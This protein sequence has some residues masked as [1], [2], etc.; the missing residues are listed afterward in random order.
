MVGKRMEAPRSKIRVLDPVVANKI[1]AGEVVERP[2]SVV[3]ELVENSLDAG[4]TRLDI[5]VEEG[6]K[7]L[8]RVADNGCGMS[9]ED[10]I[11][12]LQRHATSK[13][14]TAEDL[15]HI[16]TLGFR[17]EALPSIAAVSQMTLTTREAESPAGVQ[18]V[19]EGGTVSDFRMVGC[20]PGTTVEV[21]N[22]F[23]NTPARLKFLK[24][25]ATEIGHIMDHI[26]RFSLLYH[27]VSFRLRHNAHE[28]LVAPATEEMRHALVTVYGKEVAR[29]MIPLALEGGT[30]RIYGYIGKPAL[31]RSNRNFQAF[32]VN[33]RSVQSRVLQHALYEG[34]HTLLLSGRH[35]VAVVVLEIDP[36]LVDVNVHPAKA[37]VRF[38]RDWEVHNLLRRAVREALE[39][40]QGVGT[41]ARLEPAPTEAEVPLPNLEP[42]LPA[43]LSQPL[44]PSL[45]RPGGAAD[46][47][48][49]VELPE[50]GDS[51]FPQRILPL[52]QIKNSYILAETD[53]GLLI[54]DQHAAHERILYEQ[55][56]ARAESERV[57]SQLLVIP[58][59]LQCSP[60]EARA[61]EEHLT[62]LNELGFQ[63]EPFGREAFLVR[64]IPLPLAK[65]RYEQILRDLIDELVAT[66]TVQGLRRQQDDL[67]RLM[68]CKAAVKAGDALAPQEIEALIVQMR[69]ATMPFACNHGRPTMIRITEEEL[70]RLFKRK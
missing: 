58:F 9:Q 63:I 28:V 55:M 42:G 21:R 39:Q 35:P 8:I 25:P 32:F 33:G 11:L 40:A 26:S 12:A 5:E 53:E 48:L 30:V 45:G 36:Q 10:A 31:A 1:A 15:S 24:T 3:K 51:R 59:T 62:T 2:A 66:A 18:I 13:I 64:A 27:Q 41:G 20:P 65:Q 54:I 23:F 29:E 70:E 60:R 22:L 52:A 46:G 34:Y 44:S 17:G 16:R 7:R 43:P 57:P 19:V 49:Q 4:A 50:E 47:G 56:Q 14:S 38:T 6:G 67:L 69:Q 68:A 37:E 61:V